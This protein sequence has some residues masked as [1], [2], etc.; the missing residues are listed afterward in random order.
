MPAKIH[1]PRGTRYG[2]LT[3][4]KEVEPHVFPSGRKK[5]KFLCRCDCGT[6][7]VA[8]LDNLRSGNTSSC[9][10]LNI[11]AITTH[12]ETQNGRP[13]PEYTAYHNAKKR[14]ED[15]NRKCYHNYGGRGIEFRFDSFEQFFAELGP[16]PSPKHTVDRI[17]S[18]GHYSPQNC[19]WAT[20]Q[21]QQNN[22]R[23]NRFLTYNGKT[24]TMAQWAR[25]VGLQYKTLE[26]RI[27]QSSWPIERALTT[28]VRGK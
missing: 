24:M 14:C 1:V 3:I 19:R 20:R 8:V 23:T 10:C 16:R 28:P 7:W 4:I 17:D 9:G 18:N 5:R 6:E 25:E 27:N 22:T 21:Q 26:Y 2:R 11:E 15:P 12:G 13:T